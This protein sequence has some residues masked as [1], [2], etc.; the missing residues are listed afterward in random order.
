M[1]LVT[2]KLQLSNP[3]EP[4]LAPGKPEHRDGYLQ[5]RGLR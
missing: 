4:S 1:G 3:R 5:A 2:A